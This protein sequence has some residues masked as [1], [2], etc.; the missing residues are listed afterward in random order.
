MT[1]NSSNASSPRKP[2]LSLVEDPIPALLRGMAIPASVGFFFST[3]YNVVDTWFAGRISTDALASLS[4]SFPLFFLIISMGSGLSTG[5]T[6]LMGTALGRKDRAKASHYA[7]QGMSFALICSI[8]VAV[9]GLALSPPL[10]RM[11]GAEERYLATALEYMN[12]IFA[13]TVFFLQVHMCNSVLNAQGDTRTFRNF[14]VMGFVL[15]CVLDPWF[16]F[17][18]LGLPAMGVRGIALATVLIQAMGCVYMGRKACQSGLVRLS[19]WRELLPEAQAYKDIARQGLPASL[20]TFTIGLGIFVITYYIS[21]FGKNA[22]AAY[23]IGTRVVQIALMPGIGLNTATLAITAQNAGACRF[24][25]V[26]EGLGTAL[27]YG[28]VIMFL[29]GAF[30]FGGAELLMKVFTSDAE[31]I[32]IGTRYLRVEALALYAYVLLSVSV[33]LLQGLKRPMFGVW[34][35]VLRQIVLPMAVFHVLLKVLGVS[36]LGIWWGIFAI[37]WSTGIFSVIYTRKVLGKVQAKAVRKC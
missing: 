16:I 14:L 25:R 24:D 9:A 28:A 11:L 1:K 20:N 4:L 18:G 29:G 27:K 33:A 3:M 10:F 37:V 19:S 13:G 26:R 22:V 23:G 30:V 6:A 35:G 36:I 2:G 21:M 31:T 34:M 8:M 12:V 17:G 32:D 7:I 5:T 15:N